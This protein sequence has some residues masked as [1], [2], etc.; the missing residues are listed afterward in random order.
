MGRNKL[1][2]RFG[3]IPLKIWKKLE[4]SIKSGYDQ[5]KETSSNYCN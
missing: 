2:H 1:P 5:A 3:S 4:T